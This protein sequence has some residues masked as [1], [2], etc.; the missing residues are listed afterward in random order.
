M[1]E[2]TSPHLQIYCS[3]DVK[4]RTSEKGD[5]EEVMADIQCISVLYLPLVVYVNTAALSKQPDTR[6]I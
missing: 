6:F 1:S 5:G 4:K 2:A 3:S